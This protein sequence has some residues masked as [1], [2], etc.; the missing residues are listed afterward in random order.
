[1]ADNVSKAARYWPT[2]NPLTFATI[3]HWI[4][5]V[6]AANT[7][8]NGKISSFTNLGSGG[9]RTQ[10]T[11]AKR[12]ALTNGEAVFTGVQQYDMSSL[13]NPN[14]TQHL[15][16]AVI[17]VPN[18]AI[19]A[20]S[21]IE[22][23]W[24]SSGWRGHL[25]IIVGNNTISFQWPTVASTGAGTNQTL[26]TGKSIA[27]LKWLPGPSTV[28]FRLNGIQVQ[29]VSTVAGVD[30]TNTLNIG[31]NAVYNS[32]VD[33]LSNVNILDCLHL[34]GAA[35]NL[36]TTQIEDIEGYLAAFSN[37]ALNSA[38]PYYQKQNR[39]FTSA[40]VFLSAA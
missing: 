6:Q 1:M 7:L 25:G 40:E 32:I 20:G 27:V 33:Y 38:H 8:I 12:A 19:A 4:S 18:P 35:A 3:R 15:F 26:R 2:Q 23:A 29:S 9:A 22:G 13:G 31:C 14:D 39:T 30:P 28:S 5:T 24:N 34:Q 36:T 11:D 16:V 17:D 21:I 37:V 10:A